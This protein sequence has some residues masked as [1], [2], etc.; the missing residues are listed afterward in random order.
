MA[1]S[2]KRSV[3]PLE[4]TATVNAKVRVEARITDAKYEVEL[5]KED[6]HFK[7]AWI[8]PPADAD[9]WMK[10][11]YS[12]DGPEGDPWPIG[13]LRIMLDVENLDPNLGDLSDLT[14]E[15]TKKE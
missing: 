11:L 4:G 6:L 1:K 3:V 13:K 10:L 5:L 7:R 9:G 2:K 12:A 8:E 15:E 14:I